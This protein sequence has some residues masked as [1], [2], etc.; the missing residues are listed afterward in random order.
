MTDINLNEQIQ[1]L[2]NLQ[3]VD[4]EIYDLQVE[5]ESFPEKINELNDS[6]E[7]KKTGMQQADEKVKQF[8]VAKS[9]K[10]NDLKA[11]EERIIKHESELAQI[12]TNKEYK[13][14]LEQIDS[15]KADISLLEEKILESYDEI[16][17]AKS[18][19][20]N[21][22]KLFEE[23]SNKNQKE[24]NEIKAREKQLDER[25][26]EL[27]TKRSEISSSVGDGLLKQYDRILQNRGRN[28]LARIDGEF[29]SECNMRLRP[30]VI[31]DVNLKKELVICEN[32]S[33]IL[34]TS[35]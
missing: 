35:E 7:S 20:E 28:A 32:C 26:N 30:Q 11:G 16:E 22:K 24:I 21:E 12:K 9:D 31:N 14:M 27:Q 33:R 18:E 4:S 29:C 13:A 10:E 5:K 19:F 17:K 15:V 25:I 23:E 6:L 3:E 1:K 34:Y 2:I 8:Q